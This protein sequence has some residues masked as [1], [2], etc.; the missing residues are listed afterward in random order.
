MPDDSRILGRSPAHDGLPAAFRLRLVWAGG[1]RLA[2]I[3]LN[4][5][6]AA[7]GYGW[8]AFIGSASESSGPNPLLSGYNSGSNNWFRV[9]LPNGTYTVTA[10]MGDYGSPSNDGI[11]YQNQLIASGS[12][13]L[14][15]VLRADVPGGGDG[16]RD[17][18]HVHRH[19]GNNPFKLNGLQ[20]TSA[21]VPVAT[22]SGAR[23][24]TPAGT[25]ITLIGSATEPNAQRLIRTPG[26]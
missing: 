26:R 1:P 23:P 6:S 13:S 16:R 22:I 9:D 18:A 10:Y 7:Q 12:T 5:Y 2:A 4:T 3:D 11:W 14:G 15:Q 20:I 24:T 17:D 8:T 25:P 19:G 21:S